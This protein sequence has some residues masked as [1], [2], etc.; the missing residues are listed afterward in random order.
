[1]Y[2]L[3]KKH[4]DIYNRFNF[5]FLEIFA[6]KIREIGY[7]YILIDK[8]AT[9]IHET[10]I[11]NIDDSSEVNLEK[12]TKNLLDH[13]EEKNY[14]EIFGDYRIEKISEEQYELM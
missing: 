10:F 1:M 14:K 5:V 2:S 12:V 13:E 9:M 6:N 3:Y 7:K 8:A 4:E 11:N